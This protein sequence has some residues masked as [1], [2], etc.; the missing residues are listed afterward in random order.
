[1]RNAALLL[2]LTILVACASSQ[3]RSTGLSRYQGP[4]ITAIAIAPGSGALGEAIGVELF[5]FGFQIVDPTGVDRTSGQDLATASAVAATPRLGRLSEQG[6]TALLVVE[7]VLAYDS[8]PQSASVRVT[9]AST[10]ETLATLSWK[11]GWGGARG[12]PADRMMR[13]DLG[14]AAREIAIVIKQSLR[15]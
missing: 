4:P 10:G 6:T 2:S 8:T 15:R 1:M 7:S 12:S 5:G 14:E 13:K 3:V 11:N 9:N